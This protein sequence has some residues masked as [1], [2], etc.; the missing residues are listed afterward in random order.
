M[1]M[2]NNRRA[3]TLSTTE[4]VCLCLMTFKRASQKEHRCVQNFHQMREKGRQITCSSLWQDS[5]VP[6]LPAISSCFESE[7]KTRRPLFRPKCPVQESCFTALAQPSGSGRRTNKCQ[8]CKHLFLFVQ[9]RT[10][11]DVVR[12]AKNG[13]LVPLIWNKEFPMETANDDLRN[14]RLI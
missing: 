2:K 1:R 5:K 7:H 10:D 6:L 4:F 14:S 11:I 3:K 9:W 8:D 12:P 13:D